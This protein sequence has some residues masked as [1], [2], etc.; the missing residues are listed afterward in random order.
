M[1][2]TKK[3]KKAQM[4]IQE[5]AFV[6]VAVIFLFG[7]I[8]LFFARFQ[9]GQ[10]QEISDQLKIVRNQNM[11]YYLASMPELIC[12]KNIISQSETSSCLD[13]DKL[14]IF[15][16]EGDKVNRK[17]ETIFTSASIQKIEIKIIYP[18]EE[19]ITIYTREDNNNTITFGTY[20]PI[21]EDSYLNKGCKLG[22]VDITT[23]L[24][25]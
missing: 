18:K 3:P 20:I 6:L 25:D 19:T 1:N 8:L 4:K 22:R 24:S 13:Y 16:E 7:L 17:Y 2:K 9:M 12:S 5:M 21:C 14:K 23:K 11:I 15:S 10:V